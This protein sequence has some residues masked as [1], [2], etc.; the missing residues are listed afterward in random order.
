M[1]KI[2]ACHLTSGHSKNDTRIFYKECQ[3][4]VAAGY[5][6]SLVVQNDGDEII[7]GVKILGVAKP[8]NRIERMLKITKQ[9]Y[10]RALECDADIYQLHDP[11]L[12]PYGIKLAK[13]GKKV[14]FDSHEFYDIQIAEKHYLPSWTRGL[15]KHMFILF[16]NYALKKI[17]AIILP[18]TFGG[19]NPFD[20]R[21][22]RTMIL[23][24]FPLLT[25]FK[26]EKSNNIKTTQG[27]I[28]YVGGLTYSR[29]IT[30]LIKA[31]Y[32]ANAKLILA[33][34]FSP[35]H[36]KSELESIKEYSCV[37]YKGYLNREEVIKTINEAT[38]GACTVLNV[39]QYNL[40]DN[41]ATKVYEYWGMGL[42][43]INSDNPYAREICERYDCGICVDP[44]NIDDITEAIE[45]LLR[46]PDIAKQMGENGRRAVHQVFNW[47]VEEQKL[48]NLYEQLIESF[49]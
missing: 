3:T 18:C 47:D 24:N 49:A 29:G 8:K 12:L 16:E 38:I 45:Y 30:H 28:C 6:V 19:V 41:F 22:K 40:G 34:K 25:E 5:D 37:E 23:G 2:K 1:S 21:A 48:L 31:C 4:L 44:E 36:Y 43:V 20:G 32:K 7:N 11:E 26:H 33:G 9:V 14:V 17:D 27:S 10:R 42:P 46:N 15:V 35:D 39:G 13:K